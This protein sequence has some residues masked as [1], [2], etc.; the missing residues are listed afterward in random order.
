MHSLYLLDIAS[1]VFVLAIILFRTIHKFKHHSEIAFAL[2][3]YSTLFFDIFH[4]ATEFTLEFYSEYYNLAY[5]FKI[6]SS[7]FFVPSLYN[8]TYPL[9]EMFPPFAELSKCK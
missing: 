6:V 2:I 5:T 4:G 1:A 8:S 9:L 7:I 3:L